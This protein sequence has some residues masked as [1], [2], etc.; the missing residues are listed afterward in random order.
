MTPA[1]TNTLLAALQETILGSKAENSQLNSRCQDARI[2][3]QKNNFL[4][5][6]DYFSLQV[7]YET[8][9]NMDGSQFKCSLA[10][11]EHGYSTILDSETLVTQSEPE[12]C[13][14]RERSHTGNA[15]K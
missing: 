12:R 3:K 10:T 8:Q 13:G 14:T 9:L 15:S 4:L 7:T 6:G 1:L 2:I 5:R 11:W